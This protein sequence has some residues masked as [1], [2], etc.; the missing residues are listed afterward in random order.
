MESQTII[1]TPLLNAQEVFESFRVDMVTDRDKAGAIQAFKFCYELSWKMMKRMLEFRGLEVGSPKDTFRKAA[2][3]KLIDS[4]EVW[5]DFQQKRNLTVHTYNFS[6][7]DEIIA[8]F[9]TFSSELNLLINRLE[10]L[11]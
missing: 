11:K 1:I 2:L 7:M 9:D 6:L 8:I 10:K 5:F 3:E 4:P